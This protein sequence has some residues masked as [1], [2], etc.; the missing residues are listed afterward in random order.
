MVEFL[1]LIDVTCLEYERKGRVGRN[2]S[3]F[4]CFFVWGFVFIMIVGFVRIGSVSFCLFLYLGY[5]E[6]GRVFFRYL[7][8]D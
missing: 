7:V 3:L 2:V 5:V 4:L 8:N 6:L 1:V